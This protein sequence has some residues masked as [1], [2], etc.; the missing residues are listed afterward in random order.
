M[1]EPPKAAAVVPTTVMPTWT[2]ARKTSG[3]ARSAASACAPDGFLRSSCCSRV[4][5]TDTIAISA[6]DS[7][8]LTST[9]AMITPISVKMV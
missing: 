2:V 5:R 8:P 7:A 6:P 1:V 3:C 9:R 4:R